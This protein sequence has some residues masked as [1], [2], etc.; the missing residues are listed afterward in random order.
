ME[1]RPKNKALCVFINSLLLNNK[2]F[3]NLVTESNKIYR[4]YSFGG[5]GIWEWL[6]WVVWF[7]SFSEAILAGAVEISQLDRGSG[8]LFWNGCL[9]QLSAEGQLLHGCWQKPFLLLTSFSQFL[10]TWTTR[11]AWFNVLTT[12]HPV[13]PRVS[14]PRKR[15]KG[16]KIPT[17]FVSEVTH[18]H[19][20]HLILL[21]RNS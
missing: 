3:Q 1:M 20:H 19:I 12:W 2:L 21:E 11:Q 9:M 4:L 18:H 17:F 13:S 8:S 10:V 14:H 15:A 7:C 6:S 5:P 16:K